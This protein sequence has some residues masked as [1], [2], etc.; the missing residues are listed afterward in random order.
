M[1]K[2]DHGETPLLRVVLVKSLK[3]SLVVSSYFAAFLFVDDIARAYGASFRIQF[4]STCSI[5][6]VF[7]VTLYALRLFPWQGERRMKKKTKLGELQSELD[8]YLEE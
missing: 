8:D 4:L 1:H 6:I 5:S 7:L 3:L 2:I